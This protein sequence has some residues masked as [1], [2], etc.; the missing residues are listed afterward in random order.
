MIATPWNTGEASLPS[1]VSPLVMYIEIG[2]RTPKLPALLFTVVEIKTCFG[3]WK[4]ITINMTGFISMETTAKLMGTCTQIDF[5]PL[6]L[7]VLYA[8]SR[9]YT[10]S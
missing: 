2:E 3:R 9:P 10:V 4:N 7:N 1:S 5:I 8:N 6:I